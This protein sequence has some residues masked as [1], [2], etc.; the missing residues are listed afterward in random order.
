MR[1]E[2]PSVTFRDLEMKERFIAYTITVAPVKMEKDVS[3]FDPNKGYLSTIN[4]GDT[5][6]ISSFFPTYNVS[7]A[8]HKINDISQ[9]VI[10]IGCPIYMV[11]IIENSI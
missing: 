2:H 9:G 8:V 11:S 10:Y 4:K 5:V 6:G 7:E 1:I 3:F